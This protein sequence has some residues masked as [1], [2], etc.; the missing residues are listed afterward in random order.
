MDL[1]ETKLPARLL[2][3]ATLRGNE[4]AWPVGDV[5]EVIEAARQANLINIGGQ[6]QLRLPAGATCECY[7]VEVDTFNSVSPDLPWSELVEKSAAAARCQFQDLQEKYDF[8]AEGRS[9]FREQV[10]ELEASGADPSSALC[11]VWYFEGENAAQRV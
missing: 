5:L 3:R 2:E 9:A 6:L 10:E 7:W 1:P 4:W 11:F 8:M